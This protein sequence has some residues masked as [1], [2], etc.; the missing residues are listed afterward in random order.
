MIISKGQ[1]NF[2][3]LS[4]ED[5]QIFFLFKVKCNVIAK[6]VLTYNKNCKVGDIILK[7]D[8]K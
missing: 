8:K 6:E 1:G 2:E 3:T 4:D 5:R 7:G